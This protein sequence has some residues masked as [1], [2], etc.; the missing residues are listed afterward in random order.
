MSHSKPIGATAGLTPT[1]FAVAVP[2]E[3]K[4]TRSRFLRLVRVLLTTATALVLPF[5]ILVRL[6]TYLYTERDL[7]TWLALAAAAVAT[8]LV[9][10]LFA[11]Y[12]SRK[13]TGRARFRTM[14]RR[15]VIPLVVGYCAYSLLYLSS[16][17][18][19]QAEVRDYYRSLHPALRIAVS[20]LILADKDIVI[21]GTKRDPVDYA[22]MDL[23]VREESLHYRQS[24]GY[25]HALDLRTLG[26]GWLKNW[27]VE[28]Y[29]S[30]MGF[31]TLRHTGTADHL[32]VSLPVR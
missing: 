18:A 15:V 2:V 13:L 24:D 7:P 30:L 27:A 14:W 26:R 1:R 11:A 28:R 19:K 22:A 6:T 8:G 4:P 9:L 10:T 31:G 5:V 16:V 12:V 3:R 23:A 20:T 17:N 32:H 25:V 29:F 21:T